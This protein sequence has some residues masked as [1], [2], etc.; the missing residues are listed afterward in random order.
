M[1]PQSNLAL[2]A[3]LQ[4]TIHDCL[5]DLIAEDE[6]VA[7]VD[8][9]NYRNVGDSATWLGQM[10][11]LSSRFGKSPSY[12]SALRDHSHDKLDEAMPS[13]PIL[14]TGG[15]TFGDLWPGH[16]ELRESIMERWPGR[17]V[18]QLPQSIHYKSEERADQLASAIARHKNFVLLVRDEESKE[19]AEKRFDCR[20][21]LCPDM[22]FAIGPI[23]PLAATRFPVLAMLRTDQ[24]KASN[25][26]FSA[27]PDVPVEDWIN[28]SRTAIRVAKALGA[29]KAVSLNPERIKD[30]KYDAAAKARLQRGIRQISRGRAI[31]TDRLHVHICSL[32]LGRPHA[33]LDNS[34]GKL[35]RFMAAFSGGTDLSY[36]ATSLDDGIAWARHQAS[37]RAA[38]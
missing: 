25:Y 14:I 10:A 7:M 9:P 33:V 35:R 1:T 19:F 24:E 11:Y 2:I 23:K 29:A 18:V 13:G 4:A 12:I 3:R 6:P 22:A 17:L 30:A 34:Y 21:R 28:E 16:Q 26:D 8:F 20:V 15:G 27:Y 5:K 38:A 31:V 32:L 37:V 36:K